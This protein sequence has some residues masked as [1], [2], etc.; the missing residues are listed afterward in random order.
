[1]LTILIFV[2]GEI[3]L[4]LDV[5]T[6]DNADKI[7]QAVNQRLTKERS[8]NVKYIAK[9][10]LKDYHEAAE[11]GSDAISK[12]GVRGYAYLTEADDPATGL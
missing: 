3:A 4:I 6:E 2:F 12:L 5:I 10:F 8:G 7:L 11:K 9:E 1:V